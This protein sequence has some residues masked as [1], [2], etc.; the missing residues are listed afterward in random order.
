[1]TPKPI[2]SHDDRGH[3]LGLA[4]PRA[5]I[6]TKGLPPSQSEPDLRPLSSTA[7]Q[8]A[9]YY[10]PPNLPQTP[11]PS[12]P[13]KPAKDQYP[14]RGRSLSRDAPRPT[15]SLGKHGGNMESNARPKRSRSP[16]KR[17]LALAKNTPTKEPKT[18]STMMTSVPYEAKTPTV[19]S[20]TKKHSLKQWSDKIR[21]GFLVSIHSSCLQALAL[22][23]SRVLT[24]KKLRE[25]LILTTTSAATQRKS[26]NQNQLLHFQSLLILLSRQDCKPILNSWSA[27]RQTSSC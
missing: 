6:S 25:K 7:L 19:S 8:Y 20:S 24:R 5:R 16:V 9:A 11:P 10:S 26:Q 27:F 22:I 21:H 1:L 4:V 12:S 14:R 3:G 15:H 13:D 17:L 18:P 23:Y 2:P